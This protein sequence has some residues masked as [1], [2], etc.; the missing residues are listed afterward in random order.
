MPPSI[1]FFAQAVVLQPDKWSNGEQIRNEFQHEGHGD[2]FMTTIVAYIM[3]LR[4]IL[5]L[6]RIRVVDSSVGIL[7]S[8]CIERL[9]P[10]SPFQTTI[11]MDIIESLKK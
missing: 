8:I 5:H 2:H 4:D 7:S 1:Q 6:W 10:L 9:Y 11:Y 3:A